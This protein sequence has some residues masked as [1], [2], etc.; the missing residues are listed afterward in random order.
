[1]TPIP[2]NHLL[3]GPPRSGKTTVIERTVTQLRDDGYDIDG[4]YSPEIRDALPGQL[5]ERLR[6]IIK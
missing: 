4:L 5:A 6:S 3:T 1:V 2:E